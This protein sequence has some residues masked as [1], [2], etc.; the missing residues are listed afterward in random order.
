MAGSI[1][2][3]LLIKNQKMPTELASL[4]RHFVTTQIPLL[5]IQSVMFE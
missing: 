2:G 1:S 5:P 4:V 3:I